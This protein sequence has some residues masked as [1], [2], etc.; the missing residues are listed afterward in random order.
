ML[1]AAAHVLH[2][3]GHVYAPAVDMVLVSALDVIEADEAARTSLQ[4]RFEVAAARVAAYGMEGLLAQIHCVWASAAAHRSDVVGLEQR[5][6][7][8]PAPM[9]PTATAHVARLSAVVALLRDDLTGARSLADW[10]LELATD[11]PD[12][13]QIGLCHAV[14]LEIEA[15]EGI[16]DSKHLELAHQ[17]LDKL[18]VV[19]APFWPPTH[20]RPKARRRAE[21]RN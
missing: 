13:Y 2:A 7:A 17:I 1:E 12:E 3:V 4:E 16:D 18:G 11:L 20:P 21:A 6:G 5:L 19:A 10:A 14:L 15:R 9:G 8:V